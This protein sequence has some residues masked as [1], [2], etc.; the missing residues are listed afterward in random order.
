LFRWSFDGLRE[1]G[2]KWDVTVM[3]LYPT[4]SDWATRNAQCLANMNDMVARYGK[5][6]M[7]TEVGMSWDQ[8]LA[9]NS[10]FAD[11]MAKTKS[12]SGN[13]GLGVL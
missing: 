1:N 11:L 2:G 9:A 4:P 5:E 3:S 10:F 8:A 12:I 6:V 7:I 13:K